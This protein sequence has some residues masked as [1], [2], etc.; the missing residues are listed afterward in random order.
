M[1]QGSSRRGGNFA[2][3]LSDAK[4]GKTESSEGRRKIS[5]QRESI[6]QSARHRYRAFASFFRLLKCISIIWHDTQLTID[7]NSSK[8]ESI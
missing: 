5:E 1:P 3:L 2:N 6:F 7:D 8:I 4:R